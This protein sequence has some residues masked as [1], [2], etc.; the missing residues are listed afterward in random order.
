MNSTSTPL[1][2]I[3]AIK[4][5]EQTALETLNIASI[6]LM[7]RA[8][9]FILGYLYKSYPDVKKIAVIVGAGRNGGDG[10]FFAQ[11]ALSAGF[12]VKVYYLAEPNN[13]VD[14]VRKAYLAA[15]GMG[16]PCES[17]S[18]SSLDDADLII[19]AMMGTGVNRALSGEWL[20]AAMLINRSG[21]PVISID[22]PS[23]MNANTGAILSE[24][25]KAT[26]TI[27]FIAQKPGLYTG[28]GPEYVGKVICSDLGIPQACFESVRAASCCFNLPAMAEWFPDRK[29]FNHKGNFGHVLVVG[30]YIGMAGAA[31]LAGHAALRIGA[32][33][34]S[35][36]THPHHATAMIPYHPE[37]M[38]HGVHNSEEMA[39]LLDIA[40]CIVVGCG[41]GTN[42]WSID[43]MNAVLASGKPLVIDA[44]GLNL[45]AKGAVSKE[46]LDENI[47]NMV[48]TPHPVE[49]ARLLHGTVN[50]VEAD[51]LVTANQLSSR[52]GI[53]V[54]KGAGSLVCD[55]D[56]LSINTTG[57]PAMASSGMGDALSGII[58]GLIV[59]GVSIRRATRLGV[60]LHGLSGDL[61]AK[62]GY[63]SVIA[64]DVIEFLP[65]AIAKLKE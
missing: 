56:F 10:Y 2:D 59:Q 31:L 45:I 16:V 57:N 11:Q 18:S 54:L 36:A 8:A 7:Q 32:G 40:T 25:V 55:S 19:D 15:K 20:G 65:E 30:G 41:L 63:R 5:I 27:T 38:V 35:I 49:A 12:D 37:L 60:W 43:L 34:V 64:T 23:G 50:D 17:F 58:G 46:L 21:K 13:L 33:R 48:I 52:F 62:D 6:T 26:E 14:D 51:R 9:L 28:K 44:D 61:C 22:V 47:D 24:A 1:Y 53:T 39:H 29:K 4:E 3:K 42:E